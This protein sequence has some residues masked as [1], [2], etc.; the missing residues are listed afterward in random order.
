[1]NTDD[2]T[3]AQPLL[4]FQVSLNEE[5]AYL[6]IALGARAELDLGERAHHYSLLT[7][8]RRRMDDARQGLDPSSQGWIQLDQLSRMLGLDPSHLNI[9]IH[10]A[11]SQIARALP[12]GATL[13][14]VVERRRGELRLGSVPFQILRG[15]RLEGVCGPDVIA[16]NAA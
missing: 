14:D 3:T 15:S 10:R 11:R 2:S 16:C 8:A 4:R 5:H 1:M 12:D 13:P 9:Q 6:R 7:L